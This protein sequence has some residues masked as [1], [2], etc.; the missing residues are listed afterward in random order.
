MNLP[1]F[2]PLTVIDDCQNEG[3]ITVADAGRLGNQMCQ[4]ATLMATSKLINAT[5]V[6]SYRMSKI[7]TKV[8]PNLTIPVLNCSQSLNWTYT[9]EDELKTLDP[10]ISREQ[11]IFIEGFPAELPL[12]HPFR[13][14]VL[15]EFKFDLGLEGS[16]KQFLRQ[17]A[18][19]TG[20]E[21]FVGMHVRRSDY[22]VFLKRTYNGRL[23]SKKYF[24]EAKSFLQ[25]K[26]LNSK[27]VFIV[28]S[29]D[30]KWCHE[31]FASQDD[32][33]MTNCD[34]SAELDLAILSQCDHSIIRL[35]VL[36]E[37]AS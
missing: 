20:A 31:M 14:T 36:Y 35:V 29:D 37:N 9:N 10:S 1:Y 25:Q 24:M 23:L 7:L 21:I 6:I 17:V 27:L 8:F 2:R 26:M 22:A 13:Q 4:Y 30:H 16:A 15:Q 28:A 19:D 3:L 12:F 18:Q 33:K 32:V 5:P 11:N 34:N